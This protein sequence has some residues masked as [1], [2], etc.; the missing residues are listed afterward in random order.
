ML[1]PLK[2]LATDLQRKTT[3][4]FATRPLL[5]LTA[6]LLLFLEYA[7]RLSWAAGGGS[8]SRIPYAGAQAG[9][10]LRSRPFQVCDG[11]AG[12]PG[13]EAC[14]RNRTFEPGREAHSTSLDALSPHVAVV[15]EISH[16]AAFVGQQLSVIY[17][18]RCSIPPLAVDDPQDFTGF[19]P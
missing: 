6:F 19:G 10:R 16:G 5:A 11:R 8:G 17:K 9:R 7:I 1:Q 14:W 3:A 2:A 13:G 4:G 18:L 15:T 12:L